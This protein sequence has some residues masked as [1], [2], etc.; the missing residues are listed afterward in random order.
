VLLGYL[1]RTIHGQGEKYSSLILLGWLCFGF[2]SLLRIYSGFKAVIGRMPIAAALEGQFL[3][4][5][6]QDVFSCVGEPA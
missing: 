3:R 6:G 5:G 4:F 2:S 1:F